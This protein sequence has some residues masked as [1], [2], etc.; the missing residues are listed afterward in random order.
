MSDFESKLILLRKLI[1]ESLESHVR[2]N[3]LISM[4]EPVNYILLNKGKRLRP[5]L[6]LIVA[7]TFGSKIENAVDV[8]VA[9]EML[10]NFTLV[11]DDIMDKDDFRRGKQTV[12][13]KWNL[14]VAILT[15]D[16]LIGLAHN[17]LTFAPQNKIGE[18]VRIMNETNLAL[19]EGQN[20]DKD[21]E[22]RSDVTIFEYL[23]MI[24]LK[25]AKLL[26]VCAK[27]GALIA[28]ATKE[29]VEAVEDFG[30]QLGL[31]FQIQDD[32]LDIVAE[33]ELLGKDTGSDL[34]EG[35]K[36]FPYLH[37]IETLQ[38]E[39]LERFLSLTGKGEISKE[40]L[41]TVTTLLKENGTI[42]ACQKEIDSH[43]KKAQ[44][45]LNSLKG[46]DT[47]DLVNYLNLVVKRKY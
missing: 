13:K 2:E 39:K 10:H 47:Q 21:F 32:L 3:K 34:A 7:E 27:A 45:C 17:A 26:S 40:Q 15:G 31:A 25:T 28:N 22:N 9:F 14:S 38:G 36:A 37:A 12:H 44:E 30:L 46:R 29:E 16:A 24:S 33:L 19:C 11:H 4:S 18:L 41:K 23:N 1:D 42:E 20:L 6:S 43:F 35:K 5:I 8:A